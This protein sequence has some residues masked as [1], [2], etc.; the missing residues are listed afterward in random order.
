MITYEAGRNDLLIIYQLVM[1]IQFSNFVSFG[2]SFSLDIINDP[3]H[4]S[5]LGG[6]DR[7]LHFYL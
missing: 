2:V 6:N 3:P 4:P 1:Y 7:N 5:R